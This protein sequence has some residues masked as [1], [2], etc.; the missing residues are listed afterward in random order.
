MACHELEFEETVLSEP[1]GASGY[2]GLFES[3]IVVDS[4][5]MAAGKFGSVV[6]ADCTTSPSFLA[7]GTGSAVPG[8]ASGLVAL[9]SA[10]SAQA[11]PAV[12]KG[13]ELAESAESAAVRAAALCGTVRQ[14]AQARHAE[15]AMSGRG[16]RARG[17]PVE[18]VHALVTRK[19]PVAGTAG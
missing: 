15:I 8:A 17:R 11:G 1:P 9:M 16:N 12:Q 7:A 13:I 3:V 6:V 4:G 14:S 2:S 10:L 19:R 18:A 5:S